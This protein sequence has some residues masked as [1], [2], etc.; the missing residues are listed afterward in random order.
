MHNRYQQKNV[1]VTEE[2]EKMY[3]I[4][5]SANKKITIT[6]QEEVDIKEKEDNHNHKWDDTYIFE[7][8]PFWQILKDYSKWADDITL[9]EQSTYRRKM[10]ISIEA[11]KKNI[12]QI[13]IERERLEQIAEDQKCNLILLLKPYGNHLIECDYD[14]DKLPLT[15]IVAKKKNDEYLS[16]LAELE[17]INE[18][19]DDIN[20]DV[21]ISSRQREAHEGVIKAAL[22][23]DMLRTR[24]KMMSSIDKKKFYKIYVQNKEH[25]KTLVEQMAQAA[26]A[27]N[28]KDNKISNEILKDGFGA[29]KNSGYTSNKDYVK[30]MLKNELSKKSEKKKERELII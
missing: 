14:I 24:L 15:A 23:N 28:S 10:T 1:Y 18:R 8:P 22:D 26:V 30:D 25:L 19:I 3:E 29:L 20:N 5:T 12:Q 17:R 7:K 16:T 9:H 2:D 21:T 4:I 27:Q 6:Y 11:N 13:K